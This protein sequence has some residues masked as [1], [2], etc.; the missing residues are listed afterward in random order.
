MTKKQLLEKK[1]E[2]IEKME[3][4]LNSADIEKRAISDAEELTYTSLEKELREL[5]TI[6]AETEKQENIGGNDMEKREFAQQLLQGEVRSDSTTH[7]NAIP[8]NIAN[9]IV[10]KLYEVSNVVSNAQMVQANGDLEFLV[11]KEDGFAQVLGETDEITPVDLKAF[12]KVVLKDK[13][14]GDLVLVSKRLLMNAPAVG[15]DYIVNTL[16]KRVGRTLEKEIFQADG[17]ATHLTSG[18]LKGDIVNLSVVDSISIDDLQKLILEMNPVL[19]NGAKFYMSRETFN[20]VA[21]LKDADGKFYVTRD[22]INDKPSYKVLG[23]EIEITPS[24]EGLSVV[25]ANVNSAIKMKLAENTSIQ[26]LT[27]KYATSGQIGVL[28]EFYGDV[29]LVNRQA[30]RVLK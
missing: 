17:T 2:I 20:K 10:E 30:V 23:I 19:L 22:M 26:V 27:E 12:D 9:E 7:S 15:I 24:V 1:N 28:A 4:I 29:A 11:E 5:N 3:A 18:L 6:L 25:L 13:R 16:A 21:L 14:I 8:A